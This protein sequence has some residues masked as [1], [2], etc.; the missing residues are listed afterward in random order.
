MRVSP[1]DVEGRECNCQEKAMLRLLSD[2]FS[3]A[4]SKKMIEKLKDGYC[5]WNDDSDSTLINYLWNALTEQMFKAEKRRGVDTTDNFNPQ[6]LI[7]IANYC[8]FIWNLT[9]DN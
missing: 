1:E 5:G 9:D 8:A 4:M 7:D 3:F 2:R 6:D